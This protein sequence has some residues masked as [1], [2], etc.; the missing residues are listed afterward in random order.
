[1]NSESDNIIIKLNNK[2]YNLFCMFFDST[3]QSSYTKFYY[4]KINNGLLISIYEEGYPYLNIECGNELV[5]NYINQFY[6]YNETKKEL[7]EE[8][9]L[10]VL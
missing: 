4:N 5:V 3:E 9:L 8:L 10:K 1:M 6:F 7:N 2:E